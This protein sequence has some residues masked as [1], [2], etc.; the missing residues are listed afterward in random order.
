MHPTQAFV[1]TMKF[2]SLN[3]CF[4]PKIWLLNILRIYYLFRISVRSKQRLYILNSPILIVYEA[5]LVRHNSK[6]YKYIQ[7]YK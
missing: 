7:L 3:V 6:V 4:C 5:K 2:Y 1:W